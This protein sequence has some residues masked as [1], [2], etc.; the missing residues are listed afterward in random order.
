[1][2]WGTVSTTA[3]YAARAALPLLHVWCGALFLPQL[4]RRQSLLLLPGP[5]QWKRLS[6]LRPGRRRKRVRK[7]RRTRGRPSPGPEAAADLPSL[8]S[9]DVERQGTTADHAR[10]TRKVISRSAAIVQRE[11]DLAGRALVVS[12]IADSPEDLADSIVPAI[13]HR[14]EIEDG[15]LAIHSLGP[16]SFLLISPD[17]A[18]ATRIFNGGRPFNLPPARLHLMRWSR[19]LGSSASSLPSRVEVDLRG[20]P[21]HAWDLDTAA[22]LLDDWCLPCDVHPMTAIQRKTF[23]LAAWCSNPGDI[24]PVIQL[25]IAEPWVAA[26]SGATGTAVPALPR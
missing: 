7:R 12:V 11:E 21:A 24:P 25:E 23:R 14:F 19:F 18:T 8:A 6:L 4:R 1:M 9:S 10:W 3:R 26:G 2:R 13:A 20:I 16:A 5:L 17:D 22:Q 15:L